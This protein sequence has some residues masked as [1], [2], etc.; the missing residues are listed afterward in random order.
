MNTKSRGE[1]E[2]K[3]EKEVKREI[4]EDRNYGYNLGAVS[5]ILQH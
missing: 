4:D 5:R 2:K 1:E 3:T